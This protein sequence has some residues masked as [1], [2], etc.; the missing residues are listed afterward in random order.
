MQLE[1][2]HQDIKSSNLAYAHGR[3]SRNNAGHVTLGVVS[4]CLLLSASRL[5]GDEVTKWN[6]IAGKAAFASG[7][8]VVRA[9]HFSNRGF[10]RSRTQP[11]TTR[12]M[13]LTGATN[14]TR[15]T[16]R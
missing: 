4:L 7:L 6:E 15:S 3:A 13:P 16:G 14:R 1:R 9:I 11:F 12:S 5:A 2:T 10:M 8:A